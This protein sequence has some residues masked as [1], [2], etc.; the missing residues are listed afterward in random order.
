MYPHA[1]ALQLWQPPIGSRNFLILCS[2]R[3]SGQKPRQGHAL[4]YGQKMAAFTYTSHHLSGAT[5]PFLL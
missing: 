2:G 4:D 5:A 1:P 3:K